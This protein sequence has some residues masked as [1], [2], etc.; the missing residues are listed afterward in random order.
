MV[1]KQPYRYRSE[2]FWGLKRLVHF[3]KQVTCKSG[4]GQSSIEMGPECMQG[5]RDW[6]DSVPA[7]S[8]HPGISVSSAACVLKGSCYSF[9]ILFSLM[10]LPFVG[11]TGGQDS[12]AR[13]KNS[14]KYLVPI[15]VINTWVATEN[16]RIITGFCFP[17]N[18]R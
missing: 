17:L 12:V 16:N 9:W 13:T 3:Q 7:G 11:A 8:L 15:Q 1:G 18:Q 6:S 4:S 14:I 10:L 2:D 5:T